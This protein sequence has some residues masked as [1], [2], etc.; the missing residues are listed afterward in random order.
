MKLGK[1][2]E[3]IN[4]FARAIEKNPQEQKAYIFKG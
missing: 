2:E 1:K 3:A 4:D